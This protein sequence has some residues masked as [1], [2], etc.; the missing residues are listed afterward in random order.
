MSETYRLDR[1]ILRNRRNNLPG[2]T[3]TRIGV[4]FIDYSSSFENSLSVAIEGWRSHVAAVIYGREDT[5]EGLDIASWYSKLLASALSEPSCLEEL[6]RVRI[7]KLQLSL[8]GEIDS[9]EM[10]FL[11]EILI[12]AQKLSQ[13]SHRSAALVEYI[14]EVGSSRTKIIVFC[15]EISVADAV[16]KYLKWNQSVPV[17]RYVN[18]HDMEEGA[19]NLNG[20]L[21]SPDQRILVCDAS[22][23]EGL[24]LQGGDKIIVHFDLP[25]SPNRI[26]QR[27]GRVDRYGSG[28]PIRSLALRC[29]ND[30][31]EMAWASCLDKGMGV[32]NHSTAC[33]QYLI[34]NELNRLSRALLIDG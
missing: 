20:F 11:K 6:V 30:P 33:L 9:T 4:T 34:E 8:E 28:E 3:P 29:I 16:A 5:Y 10:Q 31:F 13:E 26:E 14:K 32:F 27:I 18:R 2:I 12:A 23:E 21:N 19:T 22:A 1:R 17:D 24:N 7:E 25:L 15:T